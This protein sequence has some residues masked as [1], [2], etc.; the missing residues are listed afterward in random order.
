MGQVC[1]GA[2]EWQKRKSQIRLFAFSDS[3]FIIA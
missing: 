3:K 1:M 2:A